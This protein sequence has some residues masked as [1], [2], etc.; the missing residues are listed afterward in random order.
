MPASASPLSKRWRREY[1]N[2]KI[3]LY[4]VLQSFHFVIWKK[5]FSVY[6]KTVNGNGVA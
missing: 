4:I 1:S 5:E 2:V 6:S 3:E